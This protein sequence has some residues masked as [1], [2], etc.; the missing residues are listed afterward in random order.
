MMKKLLSILTALCLMLPGLACAESKESLQIDMSKWQYDSENDIYWQVGARYCTNPADASYETLGIFVPGSYFDAAQN[1]DGSF[2]CNINETGTVN[3]FTAKSAPVLFPVNT[4][5]HKAQAAPTDFS[6]SAV[7]YTGNGFIY[8]IAGCRGKEAGIPAAVTD[9]KAAIRFIRA[10]LDV[11][12]GDTNRFVAFGMSGGGSQT[13]VLGASGNSEL[14]DPYLIDLGAADESDAINAAMCWCPITGFD[15]ADEGH[16]WSMGITRSGLDHEMQ[17]ISDGLA[18]AYADYVNAMGFTDENSQILMLEA[19][20]EGIFQAGNY[21]DYVKAVIETS[22][23]HY[24][25]D[26]TFPASAGKGNS[27]VT[28]QTAQDYIDAL[29]VDGDWVY[30]DE[31]TGT[32]SISSISA[33]S[34]HMKK[35]T[36]PVAAFDKLEAGGHDLF[37]TGDGETTHFD[38]V[39]AGLVKG[40]AYE[41]DFTDDLSR[42][43]SMENTIAYRLR[44]FS[45]LSYLMPTNMDYGTSDV[46]EYWRIRT[47]IS[48]S[49]TPLTTEINLA[50][51]LQSYGAQV[52]FDTVWGQG[53]TMAERS[54]NAET[55]FIAWVLGLYQ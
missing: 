14:Y 50:L 31:T 21:Y 27:A 2:S 51:A 7:P 9:L 32:V 48:Q 37:N 5:G 36:K 3:G 46:A 22:L 26:T 1:A 10:N 24:L 39:L 25:T 6:K 23:E 35:A 38:A 54:G 40:S 44:M 55:N 41:A 52:D 49:D 18:A 15:S 30:Y 33:F 16:E 13:A 47:G 8:V 19:S 34:R 20:D 28:Y 43:D 12:P 42:L 17:S 29:N 4:P 11:L 53:H 45:P